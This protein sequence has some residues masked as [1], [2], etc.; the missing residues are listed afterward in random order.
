MILGQETFQV[1]PD[2]PQNAVSVVFIDRRLMG[3]NY[4]I[5]YQ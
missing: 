1:S 2:L 4:Q 3:Y 5:P